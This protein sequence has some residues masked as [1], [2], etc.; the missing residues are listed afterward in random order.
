MNGKKDISCVSVVEISK[1]I[2]ELLDNVEYNNKDMLLTKEHI[3]SNLA[4]LI[5]SSNRKFRKIEK[6][7]R[8]YTNKFS[9]DSRGKLKVDF[10][11]TYNY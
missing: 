2:T 4:Q 9:V 11:S 8:N 3:K 5:N 7:N 10:T 6:R 1:K